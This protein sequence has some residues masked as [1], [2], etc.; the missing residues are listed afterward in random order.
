MLLQAK[1]ALAAVR[2][3]GNT[4]SGAAP[5]SPS[6][7]TSPHSPGYGA[8]PR[9]PG[10]WALSGSPRRKPLGESP[11]LGAFP[12]SPRTGLYGDSPRA[13]LLGISPH[14][15]LSAV[16]EW[17]SSPRRVQSC[18]TAHPRGVK[19]LSAKRVVGVTHS[20][21]GQA[22]LSA[23]TAQQTQDQQGLKPRRRLWQCKQ[24][25]KMVCRT[26]PNPLRQV[27]PLQSLAQG[28][29][30]CCWMQMTFKLAAGHTIFGGPLLCLHAVEVNFGCFPAFHA[31]LR[32]IPA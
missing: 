9:S 10:Q 16:P 24:I 15:R 32:C 30:C 28:I 31:I 5:D 23:V 21:S 19:G 29:M 14:E 11:S 17:L 20:G 6:Y 18:M 8:P 22:I 25:R 12:E 13:G 4:S 7:E 27:W 3:A 2:A 1:R 26:Q